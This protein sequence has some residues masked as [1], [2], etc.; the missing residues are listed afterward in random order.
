VRGAS[1]VFGALSLLGTPDLYG[2]ARLHSVRDE[3]LAAAEALGAEARTF[4]I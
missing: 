1:G 2:E 3:L 4:N